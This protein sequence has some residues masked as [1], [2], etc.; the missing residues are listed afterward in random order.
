MAFRALTSRTKLSRGSED[1]GGPTQ[2]GWEKDESDDGSGSTVVEEEERRDH[3]DRG[4][5]VESR[6]P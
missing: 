4:S 6:L 2:M 1:G 5:W 3:D